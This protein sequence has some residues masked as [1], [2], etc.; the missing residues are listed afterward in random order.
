MV[1]EK[2][3]LGISSLSEE[4]SKL[5]HVV[6]ENKQKIIDLLQ[7]LVKLDSVNYS[8]VRYH[9]RS[10][11]FHLVEQFFKNNQIKT[12]IIRVPIDNPHND[13]AGNE[14]QEYLN[15]IAEYSFSSNEGNKKEGKKLQFNG[16]LDTVPYDA[17]KWSK[18][19]PPLGAIIQNGKLYGRGAC[20]MKAGVAC[21][22]VAM[23]ILKECKE[24][25]SNLSGSIQLWCTP[26]EETHG[27]YGSNYMIKNHFD[28][29]NADS[30]IISES[31]AFKP[32]TSP[33]F[34]VGE[35]G[36]NW[37]QLR[38][39]GVSGHGSMP[40]LKSN[41][42]NKAIKFIHNMNQI[43]F[44]KA[45]P[46]L[47]MMD[48]LKSL[49]RR[50]KI[51]ELLNVMKSA[52]GDKNP[53]DKDGAGLGSLFK[54]TFSANMINAG[55]VVNVIPD[56]CDLSIDIR[57]LPGITTQ[58]VLDAI[59]NYCTK[60]KYKIDLP[61]DYTNPQKNNSKY[62]NLPVDVELQ[63]I[64]SG[65]GSFEDVSSPFFQLISNTFTDIYHVEPLHFFSSGFTD[66]GNLREA[67]MKN[68]VVF[69]PVGGN[70]HDN[71]EFCDLESLINAT[72]FYVLSAYR[73]LQK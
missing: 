8:E 35:K 25:N 60:L 3:N 28:K 63:I 37:F 24:L 68:I 17:L 43:K 62:T 21:Q 29:I 22:M 61:K 33:V 7:E 55:S 9:N 40:K 49:L 59:T 52:K 11:I 2:Q 30:S 10:Q 50:Y 69:G 56:S 13:S 34:V 64:T 45:K 57:A 66:A 58:Q 48:L 71:N 39:L 65:M 19:T 46:P 54:T 20:D 38:F 1:A 23:K 72:K 41:S 42:I 14:P 31:T 4:E 5:V 73:F 53:L 51:K 47:S 26:D 6:E 12:S 36:P 16:H 44:P 70:F 18:N 15:L 32:L 67:G 27:K